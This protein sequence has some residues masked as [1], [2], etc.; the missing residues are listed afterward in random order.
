MWAIYNAYV[1]FQSVS[2]D[3]AKKYTFRMFLDQF[4]LELVG[5][6]RTTAV[7]R[8]ARERNVPVRLQNV[9]LHHPEIPENGSKDCLCVVCSY[10]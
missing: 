7:R 9:G 8:E 10:K 4:S 2:P 3:S 6:Y 1:I 5:S